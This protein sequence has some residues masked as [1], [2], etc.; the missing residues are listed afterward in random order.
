[1]PQTHQL[2]DWVDKK[3]EPL[4]PFFSVLTD[5]QQRRDHKTDDRHDIN[6]DGHSG[7]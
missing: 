6:Q 1:M 2:I 4:A 3:R 7:T 5:L